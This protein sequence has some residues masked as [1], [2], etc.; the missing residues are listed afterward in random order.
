MIELVEIRV[1]TGSTTG[2][3][4]STG[5][6]TGARVSTGSTTGQGSTTGARVST[7]STTGR[8]RPPGGLDHRSVIEPV[9]IMNQVDI[10]NIQ[11][12]NGR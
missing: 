6:T 9:E 3:R 12:G 4:V 2:A 11:D 1:S 10:T 8:A 5:S 7:G